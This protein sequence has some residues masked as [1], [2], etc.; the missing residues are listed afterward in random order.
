VTM[1]YYEEM[2]MKEIGKVLDISES[3]VCQIHTSAILKL[4]A[5]LQR[6][7]TDIS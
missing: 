4:H 7:H 6:V 2:N 5:R 1:Y 3:R